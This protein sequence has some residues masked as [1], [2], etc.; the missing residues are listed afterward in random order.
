MNIP[1]TKEPQPLSRRGFL[2]ASALAGGGLLLGGT[3]AVPG[4]AGAAADTASA[5]VNAFVSITPDNVVTIMAQNPE[6]GQ[7][8]KTMLPMLIAEELDVPWEQVQVEQADYDGSKY[9]GQFAGGSMATP[10][11]YENMR[12]MGAATKAMLV[13]AAAKEWGTAPTKIT[14]ADGKLTFKKKE[15]TYGEMASAAAKV[16]PPNAR[17]LPLKDPSTFKIIGQPIGGVDNP[18]IV[19]GRPLFGIDV[20]LP[21]MK[22]AVLERC[23]VHG[24][25]VKEANLDAVLAAPGVTQAFVIDSGDS[26]LGAMGSAVVVNGVA[27]VG[28]SWWLVNEARKKLDVTWDEG[29]TKTQSTVSF[30]A[31]AE[32][33]SK[34]A[35][36]QVMKADGDASAALAGAAKTVQA[37]YSYP[38]LAHAALEPGNTTAHWKGGEIEVWSPSQTPQMANRDLAK[39]MGIG[40][41]KVTFHLTRMGGGF[42]RRLYYDYV[43]EAALIAKQ[44][45]APVK[46]LWSREDDTRHDYFRPGGYHYFEGGVDAAGKLTAWKDHFVSFGKG[47]NFAPSANMA[48]NEFPQAFVPNF[49]L[50][51]SKMELGVITGALRA[52]TSNAIAFVVQSFVDELAHAAG[53]DPLQFRLDLLDSATEGARTA[54]DPQRMKAVLETVRDQS[55]WGKAN[56]PEGTAQGVA[57]H[58]SHRGYFAE[59]VQAS[60]TKEGE[61]SVDKIWV[62]GDVGSQIINPSNAEN[63]VQGAALDGLS[64]AL[65]EEITID[66]GSIKQSNFHNFKLLRMD[67]APPVE[68]TWVKSDNAPTGLGEPALPPVPPALCNAIF[69]ITGKRVRSL[70]LSKHDLS[71][72]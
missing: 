3:F 43:L 62:A 35:P 9:S 54:F 27:I 11:H 64:Q 65:D 23:P 68:V 6:I 44:V 38:F 7:G 61:L 1:R 30:D 71:W 60:V 55:G 39:L 40:E 58:F 19:T 21:G 5:V 15:A 51:T 48:P 63:Q 42:G 59:V 4:R 70:P 45:D 31:Q 8:V 10:M 20:E 72:A 56:L 66:G 32:A 49:E 24:G 13:E 16:T 53:K 37:A 34:K 25:K 67:Q 17:S 41:D 47:N 36:E 52:P 18:K 26:P 50:G 33:L 57:F 12:R 22:Y 46:L 28:D 2:Q 29:E 69:E 14:A